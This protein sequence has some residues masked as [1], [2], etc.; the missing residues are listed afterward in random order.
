ATKSA[1][2]APLSLRERLSSRGGNSL[3]VFARLKPNVTLE[4]AQ[5]EMREIAA[6]LDK[7]YP[8]TN[9]NVQVMSLREKVVGNIRPALL[10]LFGAVGFV[11]LIGCANVSNMFLA[12]SA[13]REREIALRAA[14]GAMRWRVLRQHFVES[15]LIAAL[16]GIAGILLALWGTRVLVALGP[17]QIPR[18]ETITVDQYVVLFV[19]TISVLMGVAFGILPAWKASGANVSDALKEGHRGSTEGLRRNK[20]RGLLVS[21]EFA[22]AVILLAGAG[23]MIHTFV[24]LQNVDPGFDSHNVLSMQVGILGTEQAR[25]GHTEPFYQQVLQKVAAISGVQSASG[26]NNQSMARLH[27]PGEDPIGKRITFDDSTAKT[28]SWVTVIGVTK[29][30]VRSN[31]IGPAEEEVFVPFLQSRD[32]LQNPTGPFAYITLVVRTTTD[33]AS[34]APVVKAAIHSLDRNASISEVQ[35]MEQV[36]GKATAESRFYLILL[37]AFASVA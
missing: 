36:I 10:V 22:F 2:W 3:R 4:Q 5:A 9:R 27:W 15:L 7:E 20:L 35:T 26:I 25:A 6:R 37:G 28:S 32:Y 33:A 31:W 29:N 12:R 19:L 17:P 14:L 1:I 24:A 30:T 8:G 16:G 34:V 13:A 21:S 18:L 23:L 11:L